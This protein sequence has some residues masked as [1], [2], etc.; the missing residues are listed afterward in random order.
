MTLTKT[1]ILTAISTVIRVIT[2]F[3]INKVLAVYVG[4]SGLAMV[5]QLQ[6]FISMIRSFA[7]GAIT[8]GIVK[9][10]AQY[11]TVEQKQKI[12]STSIVVSLICSLLVSIFIFGFSEY[13]S[14]LILK[15]IK[16]SSV[17]VIFAIT[18]FLFALNSILL[19]ILN[20]QKEIKKYV[21]VNIVSSLFSLFF[22]SFL[23]IKLSLIGALY[24]MVINQS[25]VFF[26]TLIFVIKSNWFKLEYF[27]HGIDK[28]SLVKLSKYSVMAIT[29]TVL[30][31]VSHIIVRN[32]IGENLSWI[33]A[34]IWQGIWYISTIYLMIV[35]SSL[36]VYYLPKISEITS[37]QELKKEIWNGYKIIMPI[38]TILA[39]GIF[40]FKELAIE[41]AFTEEFMPMMELFKWQLIG[42]VI[43]IASWLLGYVLIAKAMT[44]LF[45]YTE[46]IFTALFVFLSI[47]FID[48]YGLVGITYAFSL[49]YL[50]YFI[51]IFI[52]FRKKF[53]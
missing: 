28:D 12:F 43:K 30:V 6:D 23:I 13:L 25:I 29:S 44:R 24:A 19:A 38:V 15:D 3:A 48:I 21:F 35:T 42:D 11:Q 1:S 33:D 4:P 34:G 27:K 32:Y 50:I 39:I 37:N 47:I 5:G 53:G 16:Y 31:S 22:T 20:G 40:L 45:I 17:F 41:I 14:D 9:Y 10:T 8:D 36:S 7:N 52:I 18:I 2:S 26:V 49:N 51:V 46:I